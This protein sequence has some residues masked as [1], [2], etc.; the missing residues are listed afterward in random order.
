MEQT[1]PS[2]TRPPS[3]AQQLQAPRGGSL[4]FRT[5]SRFIALLGIA[6]GCYGGFRVSQNMPL[7]EPPPDSGQF[8]GWDRFMSQTLDPTKN[9]M[10]VALINAD[11]ERART[12]A[13]KIMGVAA[14][15]CFAAVAL[16]RSAKR[17]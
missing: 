12:D 4:D 1:A 15:I 3:E 10:G 8:Q 7:P 6:I 2:M 16:E 17:A 14:A 5:L 9:A 13:Y 11:R